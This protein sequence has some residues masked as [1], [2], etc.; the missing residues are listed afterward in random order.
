[1]YEIF[2]YQ[3]KEFGEE[4]ETESI[5][6]DFEMAAINA[7][8]TVFPTSELQGCFFHLSQAFHRKIQS[9]GKQPQYAT[10]KKFAH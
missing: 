5:M 3:V 2:F 8:M 4:S 7:A 9:V 1:M 6:F 10:Y